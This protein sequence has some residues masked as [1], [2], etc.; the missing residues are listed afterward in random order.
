MEE[1][2]I[3]K[4]KLASVQSLLQVGTTGNSSSVGD[5]K[6]PPSIHIEKASIHLNS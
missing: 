4:V 6:S 5:S 3:I 1:H 2:S